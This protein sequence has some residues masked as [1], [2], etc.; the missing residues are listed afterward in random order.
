VDERLVDARALRDVARGRRIEPQLA[1]ERV[2]RAED[3]FLGLLDV[4][5]RHWSRGLGA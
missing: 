4:D 3:P 1:E 2:G 5:G